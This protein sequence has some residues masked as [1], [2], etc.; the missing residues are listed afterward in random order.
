LKARF[1]L[2]SNLFGAIEEDNLWCATGSKVKQSMR[3]FGR[4]P[5]NVHTHWLI[6][7][8]AFCVTS[9]HADNTNETCLA[10]WYNAFPPVVDGIVDGTDYGGCAPDPE[11]W[12]RWVITNCEARWTAYV[13]AFPYDTPSELRAAREQI[14][15]S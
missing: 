6:A 5:S 1:H 2:V 13:T 10:S 4:K 14:L 9:A 7:I 15:L 3:T 11:A 12:G 8:L